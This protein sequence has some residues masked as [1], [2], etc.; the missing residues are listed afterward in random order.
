VKRVWSSLPGG[1]FF[2][3][4][5]FR[6][7]SLRYCHLRYSILMKISRLVL[8]FSVLASVASARPQ[9]NDAAVSILGQPD[10]TSETNSDPP[11]SRSLYQVDGVAIDPT[12]GKLFVSDNGNHRILRFSSTA[13]YQTFAEAEA[14]FGQPDFTSNAPNQG[15]GPSAATLNSPATLCFDAEGTLWVA[16]TLNARVLRFDNASSKTAFGA[17]AD[18]L[19]GQPD[20]TSNGPAINST[21]DSGFDEPAG[22]AIDSAGNLFVSDNGGIPRIL[23]FANAKNAAP[24]AAASSYLGAVDGLN[25]FVPGVSGTAFSINPYGICVD[26]ADR[27]W[28]ADASNHRVLRFDQPT[29]TGDAADA[30]FGQPGFGTSTVVEPPTSESLEGP[31][32]VLVA[33]DGTLWVSDYTNYRV[34]GYLNAVTKENGAAADIVLGQ[35]NFTAA[36][37][38][39]YSAR[40]AVNPSQIAIGR[41]GSLFIGEY[42][43]GAHLKRWSDPVT[44]TAPK[45]V[46]VKGTSAKIK[47]TSA[48]AASVSYKVAGQKGSKLTGGSAASW[49]LV[50]KKLT[51][52]KTTVTVTATAFDGR[53]ASARVKATMK[54]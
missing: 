27:L 13:A 48:G 52:K 37:P 15:G 31:Y 49:S 40:A 6:R 16:D 5:A 43:F 35:A 1:Y 12:S 38:P 29:V 53:T 44:I 4:S 10:F 11:T 54:K 2:R 41:E 46:D 9:T 18:G 23:R 14:V 51:K 7:V 8:L 17:S 42:G 32:N 24:E 19:I 30:V 47:G 28:V 34:L 25:V 21:S 39:A 26:A 20:F 22:V 45:A 33:P 3:F 50:A 36:T